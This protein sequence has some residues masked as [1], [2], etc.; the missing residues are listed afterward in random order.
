MKKPNNFI[1]LSFDAEEFDMPLEYAHNIPVQEQM[2]I[3]YKGLQITTQ[4]MNAA[5][6]AATFYTTANFANQYPAEI[7]ALSQKHE[8]ASHTYYHTDFEVA[9][10][11]QSKETLESITGQPVYGLR[12]PRMRPVEMRDIKAAGYLYDS[13]I[14]PTWI[15]GRYNNLHLSRTVYTQ[16]G[17]LRLPASVSPRLRI[18]LFW[19]AFKN[20]PYS[21]F[22][23]LTLQTLRHDGYINLYVHPWEFTDIS[24]YRIPG[25]AKR[26]SGDILCERLLRLIKDLLPH[27]E[28][29]TTCNLPAIQQV[30]LQHAPA[31]TTTC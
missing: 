12:M 6:V 3:G 15:P 30:I 26:W 28:F 13:S 18:P 9:H 24:P 11:R 23:N 22:K 31:E 5:R 29:I 19:L 14:N 2:E 20:M 27:G 7:K 16:E 25:Y 8:I 17:V 21:L 4:L 1:L 10:L